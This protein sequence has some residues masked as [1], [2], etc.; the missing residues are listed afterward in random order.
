M[1][2]TNLPYVLFKSDFERMGCSVHLET[3]N[4][5]ALRIAKVFKSMGIKFWYLPLTLKDRSLANVDPFDPNLPDLTKVRIAIE[6][7][8]NFWY[9]FRE[10]LRLPLSGGELTPFILSRANVAAIWTFFNDIDFGLVLPRQ[11]GKSFCTQAIICYVMYI[12]ADNSHLA[13]IDK[14]QTNSMNIV[15]VL[16]D[17]RDSMPKWMWQPSG[18]DIENKESLSYAKKS[19][20]YSTFAAA[21]DKVSAGNVA[22]GLSLTVVHFDEVAFIRYNYITVPA[23]QAAKLNASKVARKHGL[24]S[25]TIY[26]TTAGNPDTDTGA[27]ALS[28]FEDAAPFNE[29]MY[30]L[31]THEDL[32]KLIDEIAPKTRLFLEFSYKQLGF[33]DAWFKQASSELNGN[34]DDIARDLLNIWQASS[35]ENVIPQS[36]IQQLRHSKQEPA[37][38]DLTHGFMM[39]WYMDKSIVESEEFHHR[40]FVA[41]MDTSE[42]IGRDFTTLVM[43]DPTDLNIVAV[44]RCN[45]A[46]TMQVAKYMSDLL[47]EFPNLL[48]IPERNNT[49][50]ALIDFVIQKLQDN[51]INPYKRI[52]NEVVQQRQEPKFKDINIYNYKE[53]YTERKYFGYRT[54]GSASSTSRDRLYKDIMIKALELAATRVKDSTLINEYCN[55]TVRNGRVDHKEGRHDDTVISHLLAC[56]LILSGKNVGIYGI[57]ERQVL[58]SLSAKGDSID[59]SVKELQMDLRKRIAE[60]EYKLGDRNLNYILRQSYLR[61]LSTLRPLIDNNVVE[62]TPIAASQVD[63]ERKELRQMGASDNQKAKQF[64]SQISTYYKHKKIGDTSNFFNDYSRHFQ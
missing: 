46:N 8:R 62:A 11:S 44:C 27:Y 28:I 10:C 25:P 45:V 12:L 20:I 34:Q 23:A 61:E 17:I 56:Y 54:S 39:R 63:M 51:N 15:K 19:N 38:T 13:H 36:V 43:M 1:D 55:L 18:G 58:S 7:K 59:P 24:P 29:T 4:P 3:K 42:N 31:D 26:T 9:F 60:L 47:L 53:I 30:D 6:V 48:W 33:T 2:Y 57:P 64:A 21:I 16:K 52:Y 49:G 22:R 41:G 50:I 32:V 5:S 14:S 37:F 35:N 40:P